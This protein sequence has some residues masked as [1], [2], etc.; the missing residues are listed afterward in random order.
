MAWEKVNRREP[1]LQ[2]TRDW[3]EE[4]AN[5]PLESPGDRKMWQALA[6]EITRRLGEDQPADDPLF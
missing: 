1:S 2:E 5:D 6:D 3:Y 4:R